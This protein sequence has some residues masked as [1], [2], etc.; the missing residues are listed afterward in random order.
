M[1][2]FIIPLKGNIFVIKDNNIE[3]NNILENIITSEL[4]VLLSD[5]KYILNIELLFEVLS[6]SIETL[7]LFFNKIP[8]IILDKICDI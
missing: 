4:V 6:F 3:K 8:S 2:L 7:F 5:E 1:R